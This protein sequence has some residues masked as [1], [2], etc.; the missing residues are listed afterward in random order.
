VLHF[1]PE[2]HVAAR[3]RN[4]A[5]LKYTTADL[6]ASFMDGFCVRPDVEMDIRSIE[7]PDASFDVILCNHVLEHVKEDRQA[8]AEI[9]R[10]LKKGGWAILQV[11]IDQSAAA[12]LEDDSINTDELRTKYYGADSH[13]RM[14]GLDYKDRL[15][16]V[17]FKVSVDQ[18]VME[19]DKSVAERL[20][21]DVDEDIY[22]V[23]KA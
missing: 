14:Y 4:L 23:H 1:A 3:L 19:L 5:N 15:E 16:S 18:F 7:F 22:V 20:A 6:M 13:V 9:Y 12:T 8:M 17:G 10:V 2:K 11:P 21:L